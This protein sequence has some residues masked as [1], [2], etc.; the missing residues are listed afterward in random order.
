M[1]AVCYTLI[2]WV[3]LYPGWSDNICVFCLCA[4]EGFL[5]PQTILWSGQRSWEFSNPRYYS[6][7]GSAYGVRRLLGLRVPSTTKITGLPLFWFL[8]CSAFP[9]NQEQLPNHF[10]LLRVSHL[11]QR[12][13]LVVPW[14]PHQRHRHLSLWRKMKILKWS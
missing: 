1:L 9:S 14:Q 2:L 10:W 6:I 7:Y 8:S 12:H 11:G 13:S 4:W 3:I 5:S